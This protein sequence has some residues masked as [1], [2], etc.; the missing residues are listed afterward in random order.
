M[1]LRIKTLLDSIT[2]LE[3]EINRNFERFKLFVMNSNLPD[4]MKKALLAQ[5]E[6]LLRPNISG[7]LNLG[8]LRDLTNTD[9]DLYRDPMFKNLLGSDVATIMREVKRN[10]Q[11]R[12][13]KMAKIPGYDPN[14]DPTQLEPDEKIITRKVKRMV[15]RKN[16]RGE[17]VMVEEEFEE[18]VVINTKTGEEVRK[19][20]KPIT[21]AQSSAVKNFV[22][23]HGGFAIGGA[24]ITIPKRPVAKDGQEVK[25]GQW[26]E[27]KDGKKVRII[28]GQNG[29]EVYEY[30]EQYVDENGVKRTRVK[31][32][33]MT[34]DKNG[35]DIVEEEIIGP[36][37]KK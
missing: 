14:F 26:F 21:V 9:S 7:K 23:Q 12:K 30:E 15:E 32:V 1:K 5:A 31:Q 27:D 25:V 35:N 6:T 3:K 18:E 17:I 33:K 2:D 22:D 8:E 24:K 28:Q 34:K 37:G 13:A 29:E 36:D 20:D 16:S 4:D 10:E 11:N 19:R